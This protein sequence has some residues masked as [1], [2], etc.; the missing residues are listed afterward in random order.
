MFLHYSLKLAVPGKCLGVAWFSTT[1]H[2]ETNGGRHGCTKEGENRR[3]EQSGVRGPADVPSLFRINVEV[4]NLDE[5][6]AVLWQRFD[7]PDLQP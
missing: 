6:C 7:S 1:P 2:T 4:G 5:C 3:D